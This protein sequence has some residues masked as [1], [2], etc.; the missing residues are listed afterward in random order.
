MLC[1]NLLQFT[2]KPNCFHLK[3]TFAK[4][5]IISSTFA[6]AFCSPFKHTEG[7]YTRVTVN[8]F[9][10]SGGT[11]REI[12]FF[13]LL[14]QAVLQVGVLKCR[15]LYQLLQIFCGA[16]N[17]RVHCTELSTGTFQ[18]LIEPLWL[19]RPLRE[20]SPSIAFHNCYNK[21]LKTA[22]QTKLLSCQVLHKVL[23]TLLEQQTMFQTWTRGSEVRLKGNYFPSLP[24]PFLRS[25]WSKYRRNWT[26]NCTSLEGASI[27]FCPL[28]LQ[29]VWTTK[30]VVLHFLH[31]HISLEN[32]WIFFFHRFLKP[33]KGCMFSFSN[34]IRIQPV[35]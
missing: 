22:V 14:P 26:H 27:I 9:N 30:E 28:N 7:F 31:L 1:C 33:E 8:T 19:E 25:Y 34:P 4:A 15:T 10:P 29:W 6:S 11:R 2:L 23:K 17:R 13:L 3:S 24:S 18:R 35:Q 20:T 32:I 16:I 12:I 5:Y 21:L